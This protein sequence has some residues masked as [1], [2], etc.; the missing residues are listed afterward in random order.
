MQSSSQNVTTV[1][2]YICSCAVSASLLVAGRGIHPPKYMMHFTSISYFPLFQKI[3][4]SWKNFPT[5]RK[6]FPTFQKKF[7]FHLPKCLM[8]FLGIRSDLIIP[9]IFTKNATFPPC[10]ANFAS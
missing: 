1:K 9:P 7:S 10:F 2:F 4:E 8:T 5:F 6:I 3:S